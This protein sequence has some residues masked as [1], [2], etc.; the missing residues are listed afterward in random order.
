MCSFDLEN[1]Y[2]H[3]KLHPRSV[4]Y[5]GLAL[6]DEQGIKQ[7]YQFLVMCYGYSGAVDVVT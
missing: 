3:V 1:M 2:F 6:V 4:K 5:F 7:Y